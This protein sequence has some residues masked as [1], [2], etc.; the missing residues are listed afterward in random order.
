[1]R[2]LQQAPSKMR[3][4][5]T[6]IVAIVS[7]G[8]GVTVL[9]QVDSGIEAIWHV[10]SLPFAFRGRSVA[11][12]CSSFEKKLHAILIA[13]G[14]H[15]S[16]I[17]Q[18]SCK[19]VPT[20]TRIDA[21]IA[22]ATPVPATPENIAA[23]TTFDSKRE[24]LARMQKTPLP[25]ASAIEKFRASYRT[26]LLEDKG[27][28]QLEPSDCEL[29]IAVRD[30]LFPKLNIEVEKNV[31]FCSEAVARPALLRVNALFHIDH[32]SVSAK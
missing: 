30:Q 12:T 11:Y 16:L 18:S 7:L 13:V 4:A 25:T 15:P 21:R 23:A 24:L 10:Q 31:V 29:L 5:L 27:D 22:L 1:M 20:A 6:F 14:A 32:D 17:I 9:A 2:Y 19:A 3:Q 26:V 8:S 28:L